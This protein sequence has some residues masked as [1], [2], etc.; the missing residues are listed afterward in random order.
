MSS[1][2]SAATPRE[3][4]ERTQRVILERR[5]DEYADLFAVDATFELPFAPPGMPRRIEG[6]EAIRAFFRAGRERVETASRRWEFRSVVVHETVDP[7][8]I[9]T[10][11][12]VH[13]MGPEGGEPYQ[14]S[15]LQ[16]LTVRRG[17]IASLRDYWNPLDRPELAPLVERAAG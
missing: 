6:R 11:F 10:E 14:F 1:T 12:D 7:E 9:V 15:N 17:E 13:G 3:V 16:V 4:F 5:F 2:P 8:V